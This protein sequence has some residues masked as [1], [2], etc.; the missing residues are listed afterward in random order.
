M[1]ERD[2]EQLV[3]AVIHVG[4]SPH[5]TNLRGGGLN[6]AGRIYGSSIFIGLVWSIGFRMKRAPMRFARAAKIMDT[7]M[8][9]LR[10]MVALPWKMWLTWGTYSI[11]RRRCIMDAV[12]V[13]EAIM[14]DRADI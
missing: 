4:R 10:A 8:T 13:A 5:V 6:V 1:R 2:D 14:R 11:L 7:V 12:R 9:Q 3:L